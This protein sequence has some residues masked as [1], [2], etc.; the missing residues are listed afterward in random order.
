MHKGAKH[1]G[2][3]PRDSMEAEVLKN[4]LQYLEKEMADAIRTERFEDAAIL[5]DQIKDLEG[6]SAQTST[7]S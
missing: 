1:V 6:V 7:Q 4:R 2:K 3:I 5:R